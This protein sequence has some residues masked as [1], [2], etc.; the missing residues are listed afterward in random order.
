MTCDPQRPLV[1]Q[2][3]RSVIPPTPLSDPVNEKRDLPHHPS[4]P[5][6]PVDGRH[7]G[8]LQQGVGFGE[9][10]A[11]EETLQRQTAR[12]LSTAAATPDNTQPQHCS[13]SARQ[14]AASAQQQQRQTTHRLSTA[15][16][17]PDNAQPQQRSAAQR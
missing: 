7:A 17:A 9:V 15:A 12:S 10:A 5:D 16:A 6:L 4:H 14:H 3:A 8:G 11:P 2:A 13:S 1:T